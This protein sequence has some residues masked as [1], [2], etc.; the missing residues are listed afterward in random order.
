MHTYQ[1]RTFSGHLEGWEYSDGSFIDC[2]FDNCGIRAGT[3]DR[4][5]LI[6][7]LE[8]RG[9]TQ[10]A[11][12]LHGVCIEDC[13]IRDLKKLGRIPLFF[14]GPVFKHVTLSGWLSGIKIN[15]LLE[16]IPKKSQAAWDASCK[17]YYEDVDWALD[18]RDANFQGGVTFEALPGSLIRRDQETQV[19]VSR[20]SL[21]RADWKRMVQAHPTVGIAIDWFLEGSLFSDV[22][23]IASKGASY[24]KDELAVLELLRRESV[25]K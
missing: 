1:G 24:F 21:A 13:S 10:R 11:C 9:A 18:I 15:R 8:L 5:R 12:F 3:P 19:L 16:P 7:N 25:A 22:V 2:T 17:A 23:L 6:H 14:W 4:R 20:E